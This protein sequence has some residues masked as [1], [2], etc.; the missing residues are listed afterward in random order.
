MG[1]S[2]VTLEK[3]CILHIEQ[4]YIKRITFD[5]VAIAYMALFQVAIFKGWIDIMDDAVD[6]VEVTLH[7]SN[8][9]LIIR[10]FNS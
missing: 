2:K 1:K 4:F 8:S 5:N 10:I 9:L 6:H 3:I 7:S